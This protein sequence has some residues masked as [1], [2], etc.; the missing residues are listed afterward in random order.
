M[1][2]FFYE[3]PE[4][5][6]S[7]FLTRRIV[8]DCFSNL[9]GIKNDSYR[10]PLFYELAEK[11]AKKFFNGEIELINL[12]SR[13]KIKT[14]STKLVLFYPPNYG[15]VKHTDIMPGRLTVVYFPIFPKN[16][17]APLQFWNSYDDETPVA[18]IGFIDSALIFDAKKI[19]SVENFNSYR[20]NL[21][22]SLDVPYDEVL[23]LTKQEGL[24]NPE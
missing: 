23:T 3:L 4:I 22:F 7:D 9:H 17:Y 15:A 20:I 13:C 12:I 19:H 10:G 1:D 21:Q 8:S 11:R 18:E 5:K 14:V 24:F 16:N 2:K 6:L